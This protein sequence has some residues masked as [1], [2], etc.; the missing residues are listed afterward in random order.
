MFDLT[1]GKHT[2]Q[3]FG[4]F[5]GCRTYQYRAS[6]FGQLDDLFDYGVVFF[7]LRLVDAVVHI[8][9]GDRAV[10]RDYDNIQFI[11]VPEFAGFRFSRTG[12]T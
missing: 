6:C 12:H 2:T 11:D 7:T 5:D 10:G 3:Q 9:T 1:H 8:V 4:D